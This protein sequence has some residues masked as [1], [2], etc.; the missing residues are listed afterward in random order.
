MVPR[1]HLTSQQNKRFIVEFSKSLS[2][3]DRKCTVP[4]VSVNSLKSMKHT[5]RKVP[6]RNFCFNCEVMQ[7]RIKIV[8]AKLDEL[9]ARHEA[10]LNRHETARQNAIANA[11]DTIDWEARYN[12]K[13]RLERKLNQEKKDAISQRNV[14]LS[15]ITEYENEK[16]ELEEQL[17]NVKRQIVAQNAALLKNCNEGIELEAV[18]QGVDVKFREELEQLKM[19]VKNSTRDQFMAME[20]QNDLYVSEISHNE[21]M[22]KKAH[23][24]NTELCY[25][26][27]KADKLLQDVKFAATKSTD[28]ERCL[29][30]KLDA[31]VKKFRNEASNSEAKIMTYV[32]NNFEAAV[33]I[34]LS[35]EPHPYHL[36]ESSRDLALAGSEEI[37]KLKIASEKKDDKK[38]KKQKE[39]AFTDFKQFISKIDS[40][41]EKFYQKQEKQLANSTSQIIKRLEILKQERT[42]QNTEKINLQK[43]AGE[44]NNILNMQSIS[45]TMQE[46]LKHTS[47]KFEMLNQK[48]DGMYQKIESRDEEREEL[49]ELIEEENKLMK[50]CER[51]GN[52]QQELEVKLNRAELTYDE[53]S[54]QIR[55][56]SKIVSPPGSKHKI[57]RSRENT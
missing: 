47:D 33:K 22:L 43:R 29:E 31:L 55:D 4:N 39:K 32:V 57:K 34:I 51:I 48:I 44:S 49:K 24:E 20:L 5:P 11:E 54:R 45:R 52:E 53:L 3:A 37:N 9:K 27:Q 2:F 56:G 15:K 40:V 50:A 10:Y 18:K 1:S 19:E 38:R 13:R 16:V 35:D 21:A 8:N 17:Q 12:H 25:R 41:L 7:F 46:E 42:L 36:L 28:F 30:E 26:W 6:S 23:E 14:L